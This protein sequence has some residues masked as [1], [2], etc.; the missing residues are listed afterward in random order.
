ME[1][2]NQV[3]PLPSIPNA[4][5][6]KGLEMVDRASAEGLD[7]GMDMVPYIMA[8]TTIMAVFPPWSNIG[9]T[10]EFLKR[11]ADQSTWM[12]IKKDMQ[13]VIPQWPPF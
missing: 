1:L 11:L 8:N 3:V 6:K 9:G 2:I 13:N 10:Q 7:F 12:E 5:V 4:V